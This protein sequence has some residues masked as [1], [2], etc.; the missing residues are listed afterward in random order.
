MKEWSNAPII[1]EAN[2]LSPAVQDAQK[3]AEIK[4]AAI[5]HGERMAAYAAWI[6]PKAMAERK[7]QNERESKESLA[8]TKA[9][10]GI[11][12]LE[13]LPD[14]STLPPEVRCQQPSYI[15]AWLRQQKNVPL[16]AMATIDDGVVTVL[17]NVPVKPPSLWQR[18]LDWFR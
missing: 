17:N 4:N 15:R 1:S 5:R 12:E 7:E 14:L 18:F 16:I 11:G 10:L 3:K 9:A 2:M 8:R 6:D 13:P